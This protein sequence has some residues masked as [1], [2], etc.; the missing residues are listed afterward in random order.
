[1]IFENERKEIVE[2]GVKLSN[3]GLTK[4]TGGN[5]SIFNRDKGLF[6]ITPSGIPYNDLTPEDIVVLD[7]DCNIVDGD[8]KPS[9]EVDLHRIFYKNRND[10]EGIIHAHTMYST[11]IACLHW[12]LP[13][14]HY[15]IAVAGKDVRCADYAEFGTPELAKNAFLAMEDRN[16]VLLSNHGVLTGAHD[17]ANA[18]N[19]L[20]EVEYVS[21]LY[22]RTKCIGEPIILTDEQMDVMLEKFKT[23]GQ[24]K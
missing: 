4:G 7:L 2:Y 12:K 21:E 11:T 15:M 5:I 23:Y 20:E 9:S 19:I 22:Y 14:V 10:I 6:A 3:T 18:F 13:A 8:R 17:L 1:M 16:A 24:V